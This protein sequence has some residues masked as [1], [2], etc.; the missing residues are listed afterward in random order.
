MKKLEKKYEKKPETTPAD[1]RSVKKKGD[2]GDEK[3]TPKASKKATGTS[4]TAASID[5]LEKEL[6]A[7]R[8][9]EAEKKFEDAEDDE[10]EPKS[11]MKFYEPSDFPE[12]VTIIGSGP[13]G[14]S[15]AIYASRAGLRPVVVAPPMGGQLQGKGVMVENYPAVT[16]VT[17]PAIV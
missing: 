8:E 3:D 14:L 12:R 17:G 9:A 5:D 16:G 4:L 6:A 11:T 1:N 15:A 13:A 10:E 7:R 2:K